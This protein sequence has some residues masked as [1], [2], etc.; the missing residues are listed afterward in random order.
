M[1]CA[2]G[3]L[4]PGARPRL[5]QSHEGAGGCLALAQAARWAITYWLTENG[6]DRLGGG[7]ASFKP[8]I[9]EL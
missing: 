5:A 7:R 3:A 4:Q 9:G 1:L 8:T 6:P 2:A